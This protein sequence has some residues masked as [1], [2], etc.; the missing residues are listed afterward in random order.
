M[1]EQ[2]DSQWSDLRPGGARPVDEGNAADQSG[3]SAPAVL[4]SSIPLIH[5]VP[6]QVARGAL[7]VSFR[8]C[9]WPSDSRELR[10]G[11]EQLPPYLSSPRALRSWRPLRE[12]VVTSR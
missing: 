12:F 10:K 11:P 1:H 7:S 4:I 3:L 6:R 5:R 2:V 9:L 8:V